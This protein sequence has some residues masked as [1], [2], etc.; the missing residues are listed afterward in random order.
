MIKQPTV[1]ILGAGASYPYGLPLAKDLRTQIISD[2]A[3]HIEKLLK[4]REHDEDKRDEMVQEIKEFAEAFEKSSDRS[5]DVW[6]VKN[7]SFKM[8]GKQAIASRI[9][10]GEYKGDFREKAPYSDQD[11]YS[12]LWQRM[13]DS[14]TLPDD[15]KKL[16]Q[17]ELNIITFNYDRS[18]DQ[19]LHESL[20]NAFYDT[21]HGTSTKEVV[22]ILNRRRII[23]IYG[24]IGPLVWQREPNLPYGKDPSNVW[25]GRF[26]NDIKII[27]EAENT[28]EVEKAIELITKANRI[29]FL[30]FGYAKENLEILQLPDI[31][32]NQ[33]IYGTALG[34]PKREIATIS[35]RFKKR[36]YKPDIHPLDCLQLLREFL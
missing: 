6:L 21:F 34:L 4:T 16:S 9:L 31:L 13:T 36:S 29:F 25:P 23:H 27:Y 30:G 15:Y 22:E 33:R 14:F 12:Y 24:Q 2:F 1:F 17:N 10:N 28:P 26:A 7:P 35:S 32:E 8:I 3:D 18:L 11:W 20:T 5:I 19:F